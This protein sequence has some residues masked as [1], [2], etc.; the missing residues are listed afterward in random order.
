MF[1]ILITPAIFDTRE[2][3]QEAQALAMQEAAT[4]ARDL[5][6]MVECRVYRFGRL[7]TDVFGRDVT[8]AF[9]VG[10]AVADG[11]SVRWFEVAPL[12]IVGAVA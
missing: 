6:Q 11:R 8:P 3:A 2:T 4:L 1:R 5:G 9:Q 12:R 7:A 10:R